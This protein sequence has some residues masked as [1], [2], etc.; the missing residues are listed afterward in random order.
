M[1]AVCCR[2][3]GWWS[4]VSL[5]TYDIYAYITYDI[6]AYIMKHSRTLVDTGQSCNVAI[7]DPAA[8]LG[9]LQKHYQELKKFHLELL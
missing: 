1:G 4:T 5:A 9:L 6:Y 7:I 8:K 2:K 3:W